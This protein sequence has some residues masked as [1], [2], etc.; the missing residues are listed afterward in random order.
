MTANCGTILPGSIL[1][2][3]IEKFLKNRRLRL[4]TRSKKPHE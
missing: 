4:P 2:Y 3:S 1:L